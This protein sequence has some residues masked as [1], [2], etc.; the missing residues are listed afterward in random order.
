MAWLAAIHAGAQ[1]AAVNP[2]LTQPELEYV[3]ADLRPRAGLVDAAAPAAGQALAAAGVPAFALGDAEGAAPIAPHHARPSDAAAI[4]YTSG[5]TSR[6]KGALVRHLAYTGAGAAMPEWIGL[7][8]RERLWCVLPLFHINAQAYSL[9]TALAHGYEL[10][11]S[12]KFRASAFWRD[13]AALGS[14]R[15]T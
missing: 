7:G 10:V 3:V 11:V 2:A 14:P 5:T 13:A 9:M 6:P 12:P 4:V 1:P 15:S 8:A